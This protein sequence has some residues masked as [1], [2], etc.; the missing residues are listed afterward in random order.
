MHKFEFKQ[1][2]KKIL[3]L[4]QNTKDIDVLKKVL[5]KVLIISD[6]IY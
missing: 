1:S 3:S 2:V 6:L 5:E 4:D